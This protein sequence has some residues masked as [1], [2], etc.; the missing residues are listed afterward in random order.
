MPL[1][2]P[3]AVANLVLL[4]FAA[5][6][7]AVSCSST[8][9]QGTTGAAASTAAPTATA[10]DSADDIKP[11]RKEEDIKPLYPHDGSPPDPVAQRFCE[12]I[13]D[14][15]PKR[16]AECCGATG[17][18]GYFAGEC[19]RTLSAALRLNAVKLDPA[20]ADRCIAAFTTQLEGCGWVGPI[21]PP[22]PADCETVITGLVPEKSTCRS[23]LECAESLTCLG[24][25]TTQT[26][27]CHPPKPTGTLC[28]GSVDTLAALTRQDTTESRHPECAGV[29]ARPM[30]TDA[31]ALGAPCKTNVECGPTRTC[32]AGKCSTDPLPP[33]GKPCAAGQCARGARCVKDTCIAP[34]SEGETCESDLDCQSACDKPTGKCAKRCAALPIPTKPAFTPKTAPSSSPKR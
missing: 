19:A 31:K 33:A 6:L 2:R 7:I 25:S 16:R 1:P 29:C 26:G 22:L 10:D 8:G 27:K 14:L 4:P 21:P 28:G 30:C 17:G 23:S 3:T 32:A 24:L 9:E 34:K 5:T 13:H 18:T 11:R 12:A 20:A 15:E